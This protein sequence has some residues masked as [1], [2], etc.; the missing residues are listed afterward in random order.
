MA[1]HQFAE[2]FRTLAAICTRDAEDAATDY[3]RMELLRRANAY[4]RLA[5]EGMYEND[6]SGVIA[7]AS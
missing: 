4:Y 1:T 5:A 2:R 3:Q 7:E 6:A